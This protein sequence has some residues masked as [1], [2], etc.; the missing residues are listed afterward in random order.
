MCISRG[1]TYTIDAHI[2]KFHIYRSCTYTKY[3]R[4]YGSCA[5]TKDTHI[6]K[7][8]IYER[9]AY[10]EAAHIR[11]I[12]T[13]TKDTHILIYAQLLY[14]HISTIHAHLSCIC[15][16]SLYAQLLYMCISSVY[17]KVLYTHIFR[18]CAYLS[19]MHSFRICSPKF[20]P[21]NLSHLLRKLHNIVPHPCLNYVVYNLKAQGFSLPVWTTQLRSNWACLP[22]LSL[23]LGSVYGS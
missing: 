16:S 11:K 18:I 12:C 8:C 7:L 20:H 17:V 19:Y 6:R 14:M 1:C 4:I 23:V 9:Y 3:M 5:D 15:V 13:Y 10:T 22:N 2:P 21:L